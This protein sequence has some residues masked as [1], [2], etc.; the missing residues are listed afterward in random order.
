MFLYNFFVCAKHILETIL[1]E[2]ILMSGLGLIN[3]IS[4]LNVYQF[5]DGSQWEFLNP[6]LEV[7]G[8]ALIP[9]LILVGTAGMIYAIVLGV[10]L[11]RAETTD[12]RDEAKKRL[13]N[14]I[15]A[16]VVMIALILLLQLFVSNIGTWVGDV[17]GTGDENQSGGLIRRSI[18]MLGM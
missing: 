8:A 1:M 7:L 9:I 5:E 18:A 13:I 15:I 4:Q 17:A 6:V 10:K 11:A 12:Q 3:I 14:A 16:L 2:E